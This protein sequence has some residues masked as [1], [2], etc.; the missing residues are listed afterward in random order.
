ME[1]LT[2]DRGGPALECGGLAPLC[3]IE[4]LKRR[5]YKA[6]PGHRTPRLAR[7]PSLFDPGNHNLS[8]FSP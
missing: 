2:L 1:I 4:K 6:V 7:L 3:Y 8:H 5:N